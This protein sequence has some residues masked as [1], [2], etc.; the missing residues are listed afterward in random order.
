MTVDHGRWLVGALIALAVAQAEAHETRVARASLQSVQ[1]F[2]S[3]APAL[4]LA[5][6][7]DLAVNIGANV[8]SITSAQTF[9]YTVTYRNLGG[10]GVSDAFVTFDLPQRTSLVS[11]D[12]TP[13]LSCRT[14]PSPQ[15]DLSTGA[16]GPGVAR[17]TTIVARAPNTVPAGFLN[18]RGT[19][20]ISS[21]EVGTG[22]PLPGNNFTTIDVPFIGAPELGVT[23]TGDVA[24][25]AAGLTVAYQLALSNAGTRGAAAVVVR[26]V[27]PANTTFNA[28]ASTQGWVCA[29]DIQAGS[30]CRL[31]LSTLD[32]ST[33]TT[34]RKFAVTVNADIDASVTEI[35]NTA[36]ISDNGVN[37][38]DANPQNNVASATTRVL[39]L[40]D[41]A[42]LASMTQGTF[43]AGSDANY[44][45]DLMR[46]GPKD[47]RGLR[48]TLPLRESVSLV[49]VSQPAGWSCGSSGSAPFVEVACESA[50]MT[51]DTGFDL[52][53]HVARDFAKSREILLSPV[54]STTGSIDP[55]PINNTFPVRRPVWNVADL[56][57]T[58]VPSQPSIAAGSNISFTWTVT[59][60]GPSDADGFWIQADLPFSLRFIGLSAPEGM[61]CSTPPTGT[62]NLITCRV[63]RLS[64][65]T[66]S[67]QVLANVN[68]E[69]PGGATVDFLVHVISSAI[70]R[71]PNNNQSLASIVV[72]GPPT[73]LA[74]AQLDILE[75]QA[76]PPIPITIGDAETPANDLILFATS[77]LQEVVGNAALAAGLGGTGAQRS[78]I[79][80]PEADAN[81]ACWLMLSVLDGDGLL[82]RRQLALHVA[83]VNDPPSANYAGSRHHAEGS[84]GPRAMR[85]FATNIRPGPPNES[86]QAVS[87]LVEETSDPQ[88]VVRE[89]SVSANGTLDY[90]LS[91]ESGSADLRVIAIDDGG[92][93]NGGLDRAAP[94]PFKILVGNGVDISTRIARLAPT[95]LPLS[96]TPTGAIAAQYVVTVTHHGTLPVND[97]VLRVPAPPGLVGVTWTCAT[98]FGT[99]GTAVG[100]GDA[101]VALALGVDDRATLTINGTIDP[102]QDL[103]QV[104]ATATLPAGVTAWSTE[105]DR[106]V[107]TDVI[108]ASAAFKDGFE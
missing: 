97:I 49:S 51:A 4:V 80:V 94:T 72:S 7:A 95:T 12:A 46:I 63:S 3:I 55:V 21:T 59:N 77:E 43:V 99:C 27:V 8:T 19:A 26:D 87:F 103:I 31:T 36:S 22:D 107:L 52:V 9:E 102:H 108:Q 70:D 38:M 98:S 50:E 11:T 66:A 89:A 54:V 101:Q 105:D 88:G 30:E 90:V 76:S 85:N 96:S 61:Q 78:L 16:L 39:P 41:V 84:I 20:S 2:A 75:D 104:D 82:A 48:W 74:P 28:S 18:L 25:V 83:A 1:T 60:A 93:A 40:S 68:P 5:D 92:R 69:V 106:A 37:G 14:L 73:V 24:D 6:P 23:V 34:P 15:C 57:V 79:V 47:P 100:A 35:V 65:P 67:F 13:G 62:S 71:N 33:G 29:P 86:E 81:G 10:T 58:N 56:A 44:R 91:G 45:I 53:L 64:A 17:S 32:P 42:L